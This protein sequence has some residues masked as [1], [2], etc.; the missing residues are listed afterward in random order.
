MTA[1]LVKRSFRLAGH[2]TSVAL[3]PEFWGVLEQQ[4]RQRGCSLSRLVGEVD[5]GRGERNLA[6]AL[7]VYV[8]G[9]IK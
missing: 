1:G 6:S 5:G 9:W 8:L 7:R 4:A 3:E 2:A